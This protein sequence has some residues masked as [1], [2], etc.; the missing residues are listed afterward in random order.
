[1]SLFDPFKPYWVA[2]RTGLWLLLV[3][4]VFLYG[5]GCGKDAGARE[6]DRLK[7]AHAQAEARQAQALAKLATDYRNTE[8]RMGQDFISAATQHT[9]EMRR[10]NAQS[11]AVLAGLR[12]GTLRLQ[13]H[14]AGGVSAPAATAADPGAAADAAERRAADTA[15]L[16]GIGD[17]FDAFAALCFRTLTAERRSN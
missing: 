4:A 12:A 7:A 8:R 5:R 14:W 2:I 6:V 17:E 16:V 1:M 13:K 9:E 10:A 3:A 11:N 15:T